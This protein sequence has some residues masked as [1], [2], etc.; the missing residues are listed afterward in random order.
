MYFSTWTCAMFGSCKAARTMSRRVI[1]PTSSLRVKDQHTAG[2]HGD[3]GGCDI[4]QR[5]VRSCSQQVPRNE[6]LDTHIGLVR[7][8]DDSGEQPAAATA[9]RIPGPNRVT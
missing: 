1:T 3:H 8:V 6:T 5:R 4:G 7:V 2:G 9:N